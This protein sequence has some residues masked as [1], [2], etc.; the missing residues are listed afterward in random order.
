MTGPRA[1][2]SAR[3]CEGCKRPAVTHDADGVPLCRDCFDEMLDAAADVCHGCGGKHV[4]ALDYDPTVHVGIKTAPWACLRF[5][6]RRE[7]T[8]G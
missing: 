4:G 1:S 2:V 3:K 8:A 7:R 5:L 6:V